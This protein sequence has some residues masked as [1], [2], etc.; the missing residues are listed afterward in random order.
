MPTHPRKHKPL[1]VILTPVPTEQARRAYDEALEFFAEAFA[2]YVIQRA[3][4]AVA[5]ELGVDEADIDRERGRKREDDEED[6]DA[7]LLRASS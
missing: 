1:R 2:D 3:R 7:A 6:F 4:L 5:A